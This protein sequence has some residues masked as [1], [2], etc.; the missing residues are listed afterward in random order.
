MKKFI[1]FFAVAIIL[2][3]VFAV[4]AHASML[5][6]TQ[7]FVGET[8]SALVII[9]AIVGAGSAAV[10]RNITMAV[11]ILLGGIVLAA[12]LYDPSYLMEQG[13]K[14]WELVKP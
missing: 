14:L 5:G 8:M 11:M 6:N 10:K 3:L 9:G 4:P 13:K 7:K 12:A 2:S 1:K